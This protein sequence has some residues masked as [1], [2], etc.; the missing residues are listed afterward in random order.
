MVGK[1]VQEFKGHKDK[2]RNGLINEQNSNIWLSGSYDKK[3]K[4]WDLREKKS[5]FEID[6]ESEITSMVAFP[7]NSNLIAVGGNDSHLRIFDLLNLSSSLGSSSSPSLLE[8]LNNHQKAITSLSFDGFGKR[9]ISGSI[10][11]L[12][13]IYDISDFSVKHTIK[14]SSPILSVAV[15]P[16][17]SHFV[18][19]MSD[20]LL[21]MKHRNVS[22]TENQRSNK[23]S[24]RRENSQKIENY[25]EVVSINKMPY[26]QKENK[27]KNKSFDFEKHLNRF[28]YV[29]ATDKV[30]KTKNEMV[31]ASFFSEMIQRNDIEKCLSGYNEKT[32][33]PL[34]LFLINNICNPHIS[35]ICVITSN[36]VLN[37]YGKLIGISKRFD[38]LVS[39]LSNKIKEEI[40]IQKNLRK[41]QG[42]IETFNSI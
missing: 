27:K 24:D 11:Q 5:I 9:L 19:G 41:L 39:Q 15:S 38:D 42:I 31:I 14:Y 35:H 28:E 7:T 13:K 16:D 25:E 33:Q 6:N 32:I 8:C 40:E 1:E 18:V 20:G 37:L 22:P 23:K 10:D 3:I 12:V 2:I 4:G 21:S 30:L 36:C 29:T 34:L 17:H 26:T